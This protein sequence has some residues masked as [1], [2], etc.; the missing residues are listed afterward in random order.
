MSANAFD[1]DR[2][3]CLAAGM[4]DFVAK[5][6]DP[7]ALYATLLR[8]LPGETGSASRRTPKL[9]PSGPTFPIIQGLDSHQGLQRVAGNQTLYRSLLL[10]L[11]SQQELTRRQLTQALASGQ[12]AAVKAQAH[13]LKGVAGNLGLTQVQEQARLLEGLAHQ[14]NLAAARLAWPALEV[15]LTEVSAR[16]QAQWERKRQRR[17]HLNP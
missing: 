14:E 1:E 5:P 15:T 11:A 3:A 13:A 2:T 10:E 6:V 17:L 8:W 9:P 16:I 12:I 7:E 4:N